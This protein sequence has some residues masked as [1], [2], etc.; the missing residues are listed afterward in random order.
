MSA[1]GRP[2]P[3]L[4][5]FLALMSVTFGIEGLAQERANLG[6]PSV[7]SAIPPQSGST[8][9]APSV[10]GRVIVRSE[11]DNLPNRFDSLVRAAADPALAADL[12]RQRLTDYSS[13][14]EFLESAGVATAFEPTRPDVLAGQALKRLVPP[15]SDGECLLLAQAL[16]LMYEDAR[17]GNALVVAKAQVNSNAQERTAPSRPA[18]WRS[19]SLSIA[20]RVVVSV[21]D[22]SELLSAAKRAWPA[23]TDFPWGEGNMQLSPKKGLPPPQLARHGEGYAP[24]QTAALIGQLDLLKT[25]PTGATLRS[26]WLG[27]IVLPANA[28]LAA[29]HLAQSVLLTSAAEVK[30]SQTLSA[31]LA[32]NSDSFLLL[33]R[34]W[35]VVRTRAQAALDKAPNAAGS[36]GLRLL[37]ALWF[38][39]NSKAT[40]D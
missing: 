2:F 5:R 1:V 37:E 30:I 28:C 19:K 3:R 39:E 35:P 26:A 8:V 32:G 16:R 40:G 18:A 38:G 9:N 22:G 17:I 31:A 24:M 21:W 23:A 20:P 12:S 34:H 7:S 4:I 11:V 33:E 15:K 14:V 36:A 10:P 13:V 27:D 29:W 6:A 25:G